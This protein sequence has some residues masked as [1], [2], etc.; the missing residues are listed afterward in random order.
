MASAKRKHLLGLSGSELFDHYTSELTDYRQTLFQAHLQ[1]GDR[2]FAMLEEC[3]KTGR[4]IEIKETMTGVT[5]TPFD[6]VISAS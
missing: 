4:K 2:L 1:I 6:I 5:D 3:E